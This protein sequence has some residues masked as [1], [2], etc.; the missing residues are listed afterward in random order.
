V[1]ALVRE[2][3]V[4][5]SLAQQWDVTKRDA[6]LVLQLLQPAGGYLGI[7]DETTTATAGADLTYEVDFS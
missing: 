1:R 3:A 2:R 7:G 5:Q 4:R 6:H